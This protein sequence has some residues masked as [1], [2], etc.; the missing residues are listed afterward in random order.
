MTLEKIR[1]KEKLDEDYTV[2]QSERRQPL[3]ILV[4]RLMGGRGAVT[5]YSGANSSQGYF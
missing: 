2:K 3:L 4:Q 1:M 5:A